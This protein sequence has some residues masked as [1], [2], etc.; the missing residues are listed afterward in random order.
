[1]NLL[2]INLLQIQCK[3]LQYRCN[4]CNVVFFYII[5]IKLYIVWIM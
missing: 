4:S 1:M 5:Y 2:Q 3:W